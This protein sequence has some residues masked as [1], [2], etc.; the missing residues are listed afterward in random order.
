MGD[1]SRSK[2]KHSLMG[3]P[4][5]RTELQERQLHDS[6]WDIQAQ[7]LVKIGVPGGKKRKIPLPNDNG[8]PEDG[9]ISGPHAKSH[10]LRDIPKETRIVISEDQELLQ[11]I[12]PSGEEDDES[13]SD[14]DDI[15]VTIGNIKTGAPSYMGTPM[16]LN[17]KTGRGYGAPVSAKSQPK[18]ID[19]EASGNI[20]GLPVIEVDLES[21]EDKPWRKPGADLS[22][23]FNYGFNEETWKAYCEKQ[24]RLQLGL[25]PSA[26]VCTEN[27]ITVQ[28][29]R[30]G[31]A[32]KEPENNI[33][34][35]DFKT[36]VVALVGGRIKAGPP[37][38]RKL[39]G[40]IDVIGGQAGTIR[41]VE[42]RRR[43][44]HA[45]E[46][47]PIQ[48]LGDHGSKTQPAQP[49]QQQPFV[50]QA[51]PPPALSRPPPHFL[52]PPPPPVASVPPPLHPPGLFPPPLAPP[53]A[54]L[55]PTLDGQPA[56]YS[57]RQP[58]P[59]GYNSTDS[60]FITYPPIST[61]HTPWVTTVDK[62]SSAPD[63][64]HWEYAG[65]RRERDRERDRTPTTSE[66]SNDD[67]RYR[68]Y[69]RER[70][71]DFERDYRRSRDRSRERE[72]RHRE[73]RHRDK[74][75]SSK[76]KSSRRKQHE[77]EEGESHRRHKHKKNKRNKE[78]KEASE[79]AEG[80]ELDAKE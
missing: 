19:L 52:H 42:G 25:E 76:H 37:P 1:S 51:G 46:E 21:F 17:L 62:A 59:F 65:S 9:P 5:K 55:I 58:P 15:R 16:N 35:M 36:D 20:N 10:P 26:P 32:E 34:K 27:K 63:S 45:S 18:G 66:Y 11:Q 2:G 30:T 3:G 14:D 41:R 48:V 47:N 7:L 33:I 77:S 74:E 39:G 79:D 64:G 44:K 61:S 23:Y 4:A 24:R 69:S 22:D 73:R 8:K 75:E 38:N 80:S 50:P 78:E 71:Y 13:D 43:D 68:Y 31:N 67:E 72:D 60:G 57:N 49:P 12:M 6:E 29:G 70:S 54:L 40:T 53:P 56:S 28:Q